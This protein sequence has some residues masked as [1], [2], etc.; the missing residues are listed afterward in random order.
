LGTPD[1]PLMSSNDRWQVEYRATIARPVKALIA[2]T[3]LA[4]RTRVTD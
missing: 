4:C 1:A 2:A 3:V